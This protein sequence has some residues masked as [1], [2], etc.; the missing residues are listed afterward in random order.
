MSHAPASRNVQIVEQKIFQDV[1]ERW[2]ADEDEAPMASRWR[3]DG[4]SMGS[5]GAADGQRYSLE[6][7]T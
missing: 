4:E 1:K 7:H 3:V 6:I 5:H 2:G